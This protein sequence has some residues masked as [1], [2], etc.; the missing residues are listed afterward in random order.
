MQLDKV[1]HI[2]ACFCIA[3]P[4]GI[5]NPIAGLVVA[6]LVGIGKEVYDKVSGK[7]VADFWDLVADFIGAVFGCFCSGIIF[8][9]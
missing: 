7:G 4:I 9:S 5:L 8:H 1:K 6:I 2:V 3:F